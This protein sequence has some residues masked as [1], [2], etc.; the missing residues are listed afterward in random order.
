MSIN[1]LMDIANRSLQAYQGALTAT[2]NNVANAGNE[3]YSRQRV[4]LTSE[5]PDKGTGLDYGSGINLSG[6]QRIRD[7]F[8][9]SQRFVYNS[10]QA[11][12]EKHSNILAKM[13]TLLSEPS[14]SGLS[15]LVNSFFN[16]FEELAADPTSMPLRNNVINTAQRFTDKLDTLYSGYDSLRL[17]LRNEAQN[18]V[19]DINSYL[20]QIQNLNKEIFAAETRGSSPNELLDD[21]TRVLHELSQIANITVQ[22]NTDGSVSVSIGGIFAVDRLHYL[23]F[24]LE[25]QNGS[26]KVVTERDNVAMT[27]NGGK[28]HGSTRIYNE[29]IPDYLSSLDDIANAV[30]NN[31]NAVHS[32]GF[33]FTDPPQTNIDFFDSYS[34]GTLTINQNILDDASMIAISADGNDGNNDVALQIAAMKDQDLI[35]GNSILDTYSAFVNDLAN[36]KLLQDE[37]ASSFELVINQLEGQTSEISGVSIDE[38]MVNVLK[39]QKSFDAAA[40]LV[41][42]ADELMQ[43]LLNAFG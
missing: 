25:E 12:A 22:N 3:N 4:I 39:F 29:I 28:L 7:V 36:E 17:D 20:K 24:G 31:V 41:R 19:N 37:N 42:V 27:L 14:E 43:T 21:R 13:E 18:Y 9:D 5:A 8:I 15:S 1:K 6:I 26:L 35:N 11:S 30:M 16:S 40:R 2:S 38:E 32:A 23:E 34:N 33:T 10:K